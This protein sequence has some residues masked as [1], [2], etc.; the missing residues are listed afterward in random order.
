V[1]LVGRIGDDPRLMMAGLF[2]ERA[3]S[4]AP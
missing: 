4:E 1:Q 2:L 3:L